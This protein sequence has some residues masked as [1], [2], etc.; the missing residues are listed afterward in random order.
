MKVKEIMSKSPLTVEMDTPLR[1]IK[2]VFDNVR[3]HHMLV[4]DDGK[5]FGIISDRD[6]LFALSPHI[7][8][9]AETSRDLAT[10]NK[11]AHQILTRKPITISPSA[12]IYDAIGIFNQHNIS[13]LP[14]TD[15]NQKAIG[16]LSWRDI[17]SVIE[18]NS[19]NKTN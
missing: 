7:G 12:S 6:L 1:E 5:L 13:C 2:N 10:L 15:E 8:T 9:S 16:I 14:V 19:I 4:I 3:I 18:Q 17:F 11:K